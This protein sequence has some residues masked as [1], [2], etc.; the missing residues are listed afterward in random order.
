[1]GGWGT[2]AKPLFFMSVFAL[3]CQIAA[4]PARAST[5][6]HH[7][8]SAEMADHYAQ[9]TR[10]TLRVGVHGRAMLHGR[11]YAGGGIS[12]VPFARNDSG[13][14][15]AG[16]AWQWWDNAAGTYARGSV[17]EPGSVLTFRSNG[18]MRLGH[19]A[20]VSRIINPREVEVEHA[21][22]WG[23]GMSGGVAR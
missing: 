6:R 8:P 10:H 23:A 21:N 12:C 14:A 1:M 13:I 3:S 19:V 16:N 22:W 2:S 18:R 20:V 4:P 5:T 7:Q 11:H 9:S 17:P 15:V